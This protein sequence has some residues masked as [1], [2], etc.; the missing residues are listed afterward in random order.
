MFSGGRTTREKLNTGKLAIGK[1]NNRLPN[2]ELNEG[3]E[4]M[5]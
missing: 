3:V 4:S 5:V 1:A 2:Y